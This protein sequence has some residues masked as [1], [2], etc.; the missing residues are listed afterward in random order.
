MI[1]PDVLVVGAGP[2]GL[3][4]ARDLARLGHSVVVAERE[5][6]AGGIPR[7]SDH[8]GFGLRD[9]HRSLTG[10]GYARR[11]TGQ[12]LAAGVDLRCVTTV[13]SL[14]AEDAH[15]VSPGGIE[16]LQ[17]TTVLLATG[18]RGTAPEC[19]WHSR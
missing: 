15:L 8:Q 2:A 3:S 19:P 13:T 12:A 4:A 5:A 1:R 14:T 16:T 6:E 9:L 7:H 17:P 11:L 18:A 10:P